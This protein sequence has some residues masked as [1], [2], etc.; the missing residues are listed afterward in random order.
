MCKRSKGYLWQ[1]TKVS[2]YF[3]PVA[4]VSLWS[5]ELFPLRFA[6]K[7]NNTPSTHT[8]FCVAATACACA[9]VCVCGSF[10]LLFYPDVYIL[11]INKEFNFLTTVRRFYVYG[12]GGE[13]VCGTR[14][15]TRLLCEEQTR[16]Q[17]NTYTRHAKQKT[18]RDSVDRSCS[19]ATI[20]YFVIIGLY[21]CL[22][23]CMFLYCFYDR[24]SNEGPAVVLS[25]RPRRTPPLLLRVWCP[26]SV[27]S[28]SR[29]IGA[30]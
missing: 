25:I 30:S 24:E 14:S 23:S 26:T 1:V 8:A 17:R 16:P 21:M 13:N 28:I 15:S 20:V 10:C 7:V 29:S 9:C 4:S 19:C 22:L 5:L 3:L 2:N 6:K 12:R 27:P 11:K 18:V